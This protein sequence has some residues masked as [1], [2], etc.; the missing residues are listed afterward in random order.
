MNNKS[1]CDYGESKGLS[2]AV[3][4]SLISL[5]LIFLLETMLTACSS[6]AVNSTAA[7]SSPYEQKTAQIFQ[8]ASA[9]I[10]IRGNN[11]TTCYLRVSSVDRDGPSY[12]FSVVG[13]RKEEILSLTMDQGKYRFTELRCRNSSYKLFNLPEFEIKVGVI[14]YL[15]RLDINILDKTHIQYNYETAPNI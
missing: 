8:P 5:G 3:M 14:N 15:G 7:S 9:S 10:Y 12:T 4:F 13:Q 6:I 2:I 1:R 11:K